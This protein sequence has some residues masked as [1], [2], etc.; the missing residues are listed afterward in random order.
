VA[1]A[2]LTDYQAHYDI[3]RPH[4]GIA[5]RI[6]DSEP[7][8]DPRRRDRRR[9]PTDPPKPVLS[10]LIDEYTRRLTP[11]EPQVTCRILFFVRDRRSS[12]TYR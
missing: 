4:Q 12:C 10:G 6:P 11:D 9:Q 5:Q 2:V 8:A 3:A 7:D 1:R